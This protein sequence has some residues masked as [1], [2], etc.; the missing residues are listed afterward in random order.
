M[1][2]TDVLEPEV[3]GSISFTNKFLIFIR[4]C[5]SQLI[6]ARDLRK[7][8]KVEKG[9]KPVVPGTLILLPGLVLGSLVKKIACKILIGKKKIEAG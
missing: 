4:T 3:M 1:V 6:S 9:E 2:S 5:H 8:R 7:E